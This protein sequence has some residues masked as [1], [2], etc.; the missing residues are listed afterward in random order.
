MLKSVNDSEI[1]RVTDFLAKY[2]LGVYISSKLLTYGTNRDFLKVWY[3]EAQGEIKA[4]ISS[5]YSAVTV[6]ADDTDFEEI[7]SFL[8]FYGY[9]SI[10]GEKKLIL[11]CGFDLSYEKTMYRF[12]FNDYVTDD[13]PVSS[14]DMKKVYKLIC[15]NIPGSFE[16]TNEAYLSFLSD[17]TFRQR[18]NKAR[19][20]AFIK[21]EDI[22]SCALT[23][24]E[25]KNNA[26]ISGVASSNKARGKGYG[27]KVV[28][29]LANEL[30]NEGKDVYVIAL[31]DSAKAF[32][33]KIGFNKI[34]TVGYTEV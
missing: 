7:Y 4:V 13:K 34:I 23:S 33:E 6:C 20:K 17:F 10:C 3:S 27:K 11:K 26:I 30:K 15:E 24:A 25:D 14:C 29:W 19:V 21:D 31:N 32:Y 16:D 18:R 12:D 9:K 8:S 28:L 1:S 22:L 5:F 2:P